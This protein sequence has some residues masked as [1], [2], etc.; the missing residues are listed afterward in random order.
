MRLKNSIGAFVSA[1]VFLIVVSV[2]VEG[3]VV[4]TPGLSP[5]VRSLSEAVLL[6]PLFGLGFFVLHSERWGYRS[7]YG[8]CAISVLVLF[9]SPMTS[10]VAC[11][12]GFLPLSLS[13]GLFAA[14]T[15]VVLTQARGPSDVESLGQAETDVPKKSHAFPASDRSN[16]RR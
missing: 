1:L 11:D 13:V 8:L 15:T 9:L 10:I 2:V 6:G 7:A 4:L 14:C 16:I 3:V 12:S 5:Q